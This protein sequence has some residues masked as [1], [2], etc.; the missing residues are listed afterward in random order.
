MKTINEIEQAILALDPKDLA[1]LRDWFARLDAEVW[2]QKMEQ[3]I[4][5]GRLERFAQEALSDLAQGR[6]TDL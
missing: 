4:V 1:T 6:C 3:D 5:A 2:D